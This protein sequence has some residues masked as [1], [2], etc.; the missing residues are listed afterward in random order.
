MRQ[1]ILEH[2]QDEGGNVSFKILWR[3]GWDSNSV[4]PLNP[5]K[6]L[7]LRGA[8]TATTPTIARVGYSFGTHRHPHLSFGEA[9]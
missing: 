3:R 7:I 8:T 2:T 6:L 4:A 9:A 1:R 5:R